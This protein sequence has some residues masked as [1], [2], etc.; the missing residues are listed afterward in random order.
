[1]A[2][3]G[4]DW[5]GRA[6]IAHYVPAAQRPVDVLAARPGVESAYVGVP[7]CTDVV[8]CLGNV[9]RVWVVRQGDY[10]NP[11]TGIGPDKQ[12]ALSTKFAVVRVWHYTGLT[13]ALM[14]I[15]PKTSNETS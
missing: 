1:M 9:Q 5:V 15:K 13:L 3:P 11:L 8:K 4:G 14:Q 12:D 7:E 6:T 2:D 10:D